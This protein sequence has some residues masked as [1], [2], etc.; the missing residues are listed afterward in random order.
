MLPASASSAD[1]TAAEAAIATFMADVGLIAPLPTDAIVATADP[2][3]HSAATSAGRGDEAAAAAQGCTPLPP[4]G[5]IELFLL[6]HRPEV[7]LT[8]LDFDHWSPTRHAVP[9]TRAVGQCSSLLFIIHY[10]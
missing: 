6:Q 1:R 7:L 8:W 5:K 9:S 3:N 10:Y 4:P 2:T